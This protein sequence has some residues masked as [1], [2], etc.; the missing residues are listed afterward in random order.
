MRTVKSVALALTL[1]LT[2]AA[3]TA[4][5]AG[6]TVVLNPAA[7]ANYFG[8]CPGTIKF[9]GWISSSYPVV[10]Y[11]WFRS[12]GATGPVQVVTFPPQREVR[13]PI[14]TTWT[15]GGIPALPSYAGWEAVH[16]LSPAGPDTTKAPF[17]LKCVQSPL[18]P[19]R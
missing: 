2:A 1:G 13:R 12:D 8:P 14:S 19:P 18:A 6:V 4:S 10:K 9:T 11:Q 17:T 7:P 15:L 5:A 3:T 16:I